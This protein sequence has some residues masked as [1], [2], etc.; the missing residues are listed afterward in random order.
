MKMNVKKAVLIAAQIAL[1]L[2]FA[3]AAKPKK[4][5]APAK[6]EAPKPALFTAA[7]IASSVTRFSSK[8]TIMELES[9]LT[10]TSETPLTFRTTLSTKD[11][12]EEQLIPVTLY[13]FLIST[14]GYF[15]TGSSA[16]A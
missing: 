4:S 6:T 2:A 15:L 8:S 3:S 14:E 12:Q 11:E 9:K 7:I 10:L 16:S 13:F 1:V 5:K